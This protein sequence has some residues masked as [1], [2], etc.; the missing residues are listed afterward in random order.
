MPTYEAIEGIQIGQ[1][2]PGMWEDSAI[3]SADWDIGFTDKPT[4]FIINC[5]N[6]GGIYNMNDDKLSYLVPWDIQF[7]PFR[8]SFYLESYQI[9]S[10]A[11]KRI[12]Q[13]TFVDGST[14]MDRI[15]VA[16]GDKHVFVPN[17]RGYVQ[18]VNFPVL[19]EAPEFYPPQFAVNGLVNLSKQATMFMKNA[20]AWENSIINAALKGGRLEEGGMITVTFNDSWL[21]NLWQWFTSTQAT[22]VSDEGSTH[23]SG[24]EPTNYGP[25]Y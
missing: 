19:C 6:I 9:Q 18:P 11:G 15:Y 22:D 7:G 4:K 10:A 16:L 14:L 17:N 1:F 20:N 13:L 25:K 24:N 3:F 8:F 5:V 21:Q 23:T 2:R 12:L